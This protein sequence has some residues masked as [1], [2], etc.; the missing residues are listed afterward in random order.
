MSFNKLKCSGITG[1]LWRWL[2][3]YL[4]NRF[5]CTQWTTATQS[6]YLSSLEFLRGAFL[7]LSCSSFTWMTC[8]HQ[9][10]IQSF[11]ALLM[12]V[13]ATWQS[14]IYVM[15]SSSNVLNKHSRKWKMDFNISSVK[16]SVG[17]ASVTRW[18][19]KPFLFVKVIDLGI[20]IS[21]DLSWSAHHNLLLSK[22]YSK[23]SL[24]RHTF[25]HNTPVS[26]KKTLYLFLT[27]SQLVYGSQLWRPMLLK[28]IKAIE[29]L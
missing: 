28:D 2:K 16:F 7:A 29:R 22:A 21:N 14:K 11:S 19:W 23:L 15:L 26:V 1:N 27:R 12:T 8:Q 13:S 18:I 9:C 4:S 6:S 24:I 20:V 10:L 17:Q 5:Q 3:A 25:S